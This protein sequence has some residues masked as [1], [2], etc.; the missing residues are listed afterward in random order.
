MATTTTRLGLTKPAGTEDYDVGI[1]NANS[2]R[3]DT[4]A[5]FLHVTSSTRP[6]A[7]Y[8]GQPIRETDTGKAYVCTAV[9][10]PA[11]WV[12]V[13]LT[14]E[15]TAAVNAGPTGVGAVLLARATADTTRNNSTALLDATGLSVTVAANATY[16]LDGWFY[17]A[18]N[19]TADIKFLFSGPTG[20]SGVWSLMGPALNQAPVGGSGPRINYLDAGTVAHTSAL[21][22][23]GDSQFA[24]VWAAAAP[25][26]QISTAAA[27]GTFKL[28]FA[29]NAA[30]ASDTTIKA[31]SWFRLHRVA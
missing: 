29:Q 12:Q 9:G 7:P 5:G 3:L 24:T 10:P 28:Q 13:A 31:G 17:W 18:A 19:D 11:A 30:N 1:V 20:W 4:A 2:D 23:P 8:L 27:A 14:S 25:H 22:A 16:L 26:G 6:S 15:V 21:A